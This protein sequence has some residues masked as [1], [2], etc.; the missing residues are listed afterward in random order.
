MG[1]VTIVPVVEGH[2]EVKA[3]PLL[4]RRIAADLG[5]YDLDVHQPIR[6]GRSTLAKEA[7]IAAAVEQASYRV[8]DRGGVLVL[9]DADDDCPVDLVTRLLVPARTTRPD[10]SV[11]LVIATREFEAWFLAAAS[12]LAGTCGFPS[13][14]LLPRIRRPDEMPKAGSATR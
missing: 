11:S 4:L 1:R 7:G 14:S 8:P 2:G 6:V 9:F 3:L 12:S 13:T 10:K 5:V